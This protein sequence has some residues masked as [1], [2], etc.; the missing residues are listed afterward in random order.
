MMTGINNKIAK[1]SLYK[2]EKVKGIRCEGLK[3]SDE[4][5]TSLLVLFHY[6]EKNNN[7]KWEKFKNNK[8]I[9]NDDWYKQ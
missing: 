2:S 3:I 5:N 1:I 9:M 7:E 6:N 8:M 4:I